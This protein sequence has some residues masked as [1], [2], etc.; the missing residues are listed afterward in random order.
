[1]KKLVPVFALML[2]L[3]AMF[4]YAGDGKTCAMGDKNSAAHAKAME[5][6]KA[7]DMTGKLLCKH[8][9]LHQSETCE[10]V[11]Q[12]SS[13]EKTL[14]AVCEH[15]KVDV[16]KVSEEGSAVLHIKGKLV[17]CAE[18]GKEELMIEEAT[19]VADASKK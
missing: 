7:V 14:Y 8:C 9:N 6:G 17:K 16:E 2:G 19:K 18:D 13:D 12:P 1:M 3:V 4:A 5:Q 15:S 11:F 10:K